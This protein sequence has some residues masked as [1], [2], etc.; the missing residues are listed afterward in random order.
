MEMEILI[1]DPQYWIF[2]LGVSLN[3]YEQYTKEEQWVKKE[4]DIGLLLFSVRLSWI[5]NKTKMES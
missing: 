4:L 3:R 5:F 2:S 1:F